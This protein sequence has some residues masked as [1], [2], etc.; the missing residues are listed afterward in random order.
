MALKLA[1]NY[2]ITIKMNSNYHRQVDS[3]GEQHCLLQSS[4]A[5]ACSFVRTARCLHGPQSVLHPPPQSSH[6]N[7]LL[8]E[9]KQVRLQAILHIKCQA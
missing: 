7:N 6:T 8:A 2:Q 9:E 5:L 1:I 4:A 3:C